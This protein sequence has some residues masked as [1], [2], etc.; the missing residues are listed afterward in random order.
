MINDN[1]TAS[2]EADISAREYIERIR[3]LYASSISAFAAIVVASALVRYILVDSVPRLH[4][5]NW[6]IYMVSAGMVRVIV[7]VAFKRNVSSH[8][9][10]AW[11]D[12]Y[13][14]LSFVTGMGWAYLG[15]TFLPY[16]GPVDQLTLT[17]IVVAYLAGAMTTQFPLAV[18]FFSIFL[19]PVLA[20]IYVFISSGGELNHILA[21]MLIVIALFVT[22]ATKRLRAT[23]INSLQKSFENESLILDLT[24]EKK[25]SDKLN[26]ALNEEINIR[27]QAE[28]R[29]IEARDQA[30]KASEAKSV[31]L[32]TMSHELRTPLNGILGSSGVIA[33]MD[34]APK[35]K[36][37][38]DVIN[39][40]A[41]NLKRLID[42]MLS[43][44]DLESGAIKPDF[45]KFSLNDL[46]AKY[47]RNI[48]AQAHQKGIGFSVDIGDNIPGC[49][50]G[51]PVQLEKILNICGDNAV[52][53]TSQGE[54]QLVITIDE[55]NNDYISLQFA[56]S[57]TGVGIPQHKQDTLFQAFAQV[58]GT[59][60]RQYG[61]I[62]LGLKLAKSLTEL[63]GG[64]IS[65]Q[66]KAGKG[67]TFI[68]TA[69]F[70]K[71]AERDD[72]E[73]T[74]LS[75]LIPDIDAM[76]VEESADVHQ[77]GEADRDALRPVL[78]Q[79]YQF[80][81]DCDT[82][83]ENTLQELEPMLD[84][85]RHR[86]VFLQIKQAIRKYDFDAAMK[87]LE[88]L[89]DELALNSGKH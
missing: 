11:R 8:T 57:D 80:I 30:E 18:S 25:A 68:F 42:D 69:R 62:G 17:I 34:T 6:V 43:F 27:K 31:F 19:P 24:A 9:N 35:I 44:S 10:M 22:S 41:N 46:V 78:K 45:I 76:P 79:L 86:P 74:K 65:V 16:V 5:D 83:A 60:R 72:H 75:G 88:S 36:S 26:K 50:I 51:D 52:K 38:I 84:Q 14:L 47:V 32:S 3:L 55:E 49:V 56:I 7:Y 54:I 33:E 71:L 67:S 12:G 39:K 37:Y 58:D 63:L 2:S 4:L 89:S 85:T 53:F 21:F 23:L 59:T 28:V 15:L 40:S 61:G 73:K 48:T 64:K 87:H 13:V 70:N 81:S 82:E 29:L 20:F 66:S 77:L 1:N